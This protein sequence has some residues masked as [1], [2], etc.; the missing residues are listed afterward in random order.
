MGSNGQQWAA[1]GS[2]GQ[3]WAAMGSSNGQQWAAMGSNGQHIYEFK[4]ISELLKLFMNTILHYFH[5]S[6][7]IRKFKKYGTQTEIH[8]LHGNFKNTSKYE[9]NY[10]Y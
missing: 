4:S 1:M 2:N 8:G 7:S 5:L 10:T 9:M 6:F 3:Q